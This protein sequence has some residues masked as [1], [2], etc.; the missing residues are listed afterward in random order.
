[1]D[2]SILAMTL[3]DLKIHHFKGKALIG[4]ANT[5]YFDRFENNQ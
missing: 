2:V 5:C 3:Y 1:M 4:A